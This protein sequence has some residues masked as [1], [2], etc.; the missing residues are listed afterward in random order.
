MPDIL[1]SIVSLICLPFK[2]IKSLFK[3]NNINNINSNEKF[4]DLSI[5]E[6]RKRTFRLMDIHLKGLR[7]EIFTALN[8]KK[9]NNNKNDDEN[10]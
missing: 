2:F 6:A 4:S 7:D 8:N 1:N 10:N 5:K 9:N 3:N